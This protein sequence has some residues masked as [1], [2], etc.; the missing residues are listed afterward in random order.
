MKLK[1]IGYTALSL[2]VLLS[3][4]G[5]DNGDSEN[6]KDKDKAV[7]TEEKQSESKD[8]AKKSTEEKATTEAPTTEVATTE[9]PTTEVPTTEA[10][11]TEAATT[12]V[13]S[14]HAQS[15]AAQSNTTQSN[16]VQ[17][18]GVN[19]GGA[20]NNVNNASNA[21]SIDITNVTDRQVLESIVYGNYSQMDKIRAYNSAVMNGIIP[22]G[23]VMEGPADA[24]Y[25]SSLRIES[26]QEKSVYPSNPY[27]DNPNTKKYDYLYQNN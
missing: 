11:M 2:S 13:P 15:N 24:A 22:Q 18:N 26:G 25:E 6:N 16:E 3:A 8:K 23:N 17:Q 20:Y 10:P 4:C 27:P 1:A 14:S 5:N 9:A 12:E 21:A 7:T 19:N